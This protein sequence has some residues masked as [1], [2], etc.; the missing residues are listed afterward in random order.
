MTVR[1]FLEVL[2]IFL[3]EQF[4]CEIT[5]SVYIYLLLEQSNSNLIWIYYMK[6]HKIISWIRINISEKLEVLFRVSFSNVFFVSA[7][8]KVE[9]FISFKLEVC[10]KM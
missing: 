3:S 1:I 9:N 6:Q 7:L 4:H 10:V 5:T 8:L 2:R